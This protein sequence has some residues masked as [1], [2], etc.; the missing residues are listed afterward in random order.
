[1]HWSTHSYYHSWPCLRDGIYIRLPLA[2]RAITRRPW[3]TEQTSCGVTCVS[4]EDIPI[5]ERG[6]NIIQETGNN[7]TM[8]DVWPA[9]CNLDGCMLP[10][11]AP[12]SGISRRQDDG[13]S[14]S[15]SLF[16]CCIIHKW[17]AKWPERSLLYGRT[18]LSSIDIVPP[19]ICLAS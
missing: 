16:I 8:L 15:N 17:H 18:M 11:T 1:M 5:F 2:G 10:R 3:P 6:G 12:F 7:V 9:S 4:N 14:E 13:Y 19:H